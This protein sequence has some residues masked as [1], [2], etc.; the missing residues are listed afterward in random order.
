[1][2]K[3][4][5]LYITFARPEYARRTFDAIKLAKPEILYFYSNKA[6]NNYPIEDEKNKEIRNYITEIDWPC[7]LKTFFRDEYV[8][9]Y[10]SLFSAIDWVFEKNEKA[11][12]IEEDC[13]C[14]KT[15]FSFCEELLDRYENDESIWM[16]SGDNYHDNKIFSDKSYF[17]SKNM[18]IYGWASWKSRWEKTLRK[19]Q[20]WPTIKQENLLANYFP[21]KNEFNFQKNRLEIFIQNIDKCPAWDYIFY[22][23]MIENIS[24]SIVPSKNLVENIGRNGIHSNYSIWGHHEI[25][26]DS[27]ELQNIKHPIFVISNNNFDSFHFK[28]YYLKQNNFLYRIISKMYRILNVLFTR[29]K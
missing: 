26:K 7:N 13:L 15:F 28:N 11:I 2:T 6:R 19:G 4:P 10:T 8:D 17:F 1:M 25:N 24:Y 3:I 12:I 16:I 22:I 14:S 23:T 27:K 29:Y 21:N 5:V 20:N 9:V 18:H